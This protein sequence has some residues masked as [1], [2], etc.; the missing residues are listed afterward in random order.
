MSKHTPAPWELSL[1]R[2]IVGIR[3][4]NGSLD[5][6][7]D[8]NDTVPQG[9]E[10]IANARLIA[11]APELLEALQAIMNTYVAANLCPFGVGPYN[12]ECSCNYHDAAKR[13]RA[14]IAK[15]TQ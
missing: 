14:A 5:V 1:G 3:A 11:A 2:T 10:R 7:A 13:A 15:A 9:E 8:C 6:I 4:S 12:E